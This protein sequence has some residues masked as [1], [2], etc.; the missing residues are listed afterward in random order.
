[1]LLPVKWLK[2]YVNYKEDIRT[3]S[4][5]L[6]A[7]G[8]H[9]ES[10]ENLDRNIEKVVVGKILTIS[11][12]ENADKLVVCQIDVGSETLQIVTGAK[13]IEEG[14]LVPVALVGARLADDFKIK[15]GKLRGVESFGMLCSL[16]EL[17][18]Q[19]SVIPTDAKDGIYIIE[20][21]YPLGTDI[22]EV[23]NMRDYVLE[24]EITPNRSDCL[25]ILGMARET[26][27]TL[28]EKFSK[29]EVAI[30]EETGKIGEYI[31]SVKVE[32]ENCSRYYCK[33]IK[34][35]NIGKSPIWLQTRLMEA[36]IR[37]INNIVDLTNYVMLEFGQP[38]HAFDLD[39]INGK[40]IYVRQAKDGEVL[41]TLD[42]KERKLDENDLIIADSKTP[43]ALAGVMG[44]LETEVTENTK[45]IL[46]ESASFRGKS[47]RLSSNKFNLRSEASSRHEREIDPN[48]CK[49]AGDRF[50]QLVEKI[51][52]GK[53]VADNIDKYVDLPQEKSIEFRPSMANK[54]LGINIGSDVMEEYFLG[55]GFKVEKLEDI[56]KVT[57]PT[58]RKDLTTEV[59]LI[60]EIGRLYGFH[61]IEAKPLS[62]A[63]TRGEKPYFR[64][65]EDK[66]KNILSSLGLSEILTYSFISPK[67]YDLIKIEE[68]HEL[69]DFAELINP[70]GVD[71]SVMRT[72]LISNMLKVI[73]RNYN[74]KVDSSFF[75]EIGNV[76]FPKERPVISI[77]EEKRTLAL[78]GYGE[79]IDFYLLKEVVEIL[80]SRLGIKDIE[81]IRETNNPTFHPGRTAKV[82]VEDEVIGIIGEIHPDVMENFNIKE[83]VYV[84]QIDYDKVTKLANLNISYKELPKYPAMVRDLALV[85]DKSILVG[86]LEKVIKRNGKGLIE[87]IDLFDIY[88]G[89]QIPEGK[90][91]VA[92]SV[93]YRSK[94]RTLTDEEVNSLQE[95]LIKDLEKSFEA[96]LRS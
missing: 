19:D 51:G 74:R 6:T 63:L 15:K 71:Y 65:I 85:V 20:E 75:Y 3:L 48:I 31:D 86:E 80:L 35:V 70:L 21:D 94:D 42:N 37:P 68:G 40:D 33:V 96:E 82:L 66:S 12:H 49:L 52:A 36:G 24:I 47:V 14:H 72:T 45:T 46:L 41:I 44:G 73:S 53:V 39:K 50:C 56:L 88:T 27:A 77:P 30:K 1:M 11:E 61:N 34:D 38:L 54:R 81:F 8:S 90:K 79:K 7:S 10:I 83:R 9:I 4:D 62:G 32:S 92:Y 64:I 69:R 28:G 23:L 29:P 89:D 26:A 76:F 78:G 60:E 87:S 13:N 16:E 2:D 17:G 95:N 84:G 5:K 43:I 91:S 25:S 59:D 18:Y 58:F 55:L 22:K 67:D 57:V 93:V